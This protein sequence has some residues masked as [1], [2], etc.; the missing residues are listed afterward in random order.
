MS[1]AKDITRT[2]ESERHARL[3]DRVYRSQSGLYDVTRKYYLL[4]RDQLIRDLAP[5]HGGRVLEIGCGTARN[6]ICA[7]RQ[8]PDTEYVGVDISSEMLRTARKNLKR[9]GLTGSISL[10]QGDAEDLSQSPAWDGAGFD[11]VFMSFC[12]SMIPDWQTAVRQALTLLKPS[13]ELHVVD[14]GQLENLPAPARYAL[15][16]WLAL[17][18]VKPRKLLRDFFREL[19]SETGTRTEFRQLYRGYSWQFRCQPFA[20]T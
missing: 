2:R 9:S 16:Q 15:G 4:G 3:M 11:R 18:H 8:W 19:D 14:F 10:F 5:P 6:L 1:L 13:G 7:A 20:G 17:F 12:V